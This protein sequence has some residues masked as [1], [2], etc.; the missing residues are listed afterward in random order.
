MYI[1]T[2]VFRQC[3]SACFLLT[4]GSHHWPPADTSTRNAAQL[5]ANSHQVPS[6][7]YR[8]AAQLPAGSHLALITARLMGTIRCRAQTLVISPGITHAYAVFLP[9]TNQD[10]A[11]RFGNS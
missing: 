4:T 5:P 8:N 2:Y 9:Y 10:A 7:N 1:C 11:P 3:F 6:D